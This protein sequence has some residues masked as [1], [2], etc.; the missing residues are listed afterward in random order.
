MFF[1]SLIPLAS[2][3]ATI[4]VGF[5]SGGSFTLVGVIAHEDYG[6]KNV[7]KILGTIMTGAAGAILVYD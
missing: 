3:L 6:T 7:A 1:V 5:I 2:L 4:I